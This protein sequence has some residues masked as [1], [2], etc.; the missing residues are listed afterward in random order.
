MECTP[1]L[2]RLA[3][4]PP[5]MKKE[6]NLVIVCAG[7]RDLRTTTE[8]QKLSKKKARGRGRT[9]EIRGDLLRA[10]F[11]RE[12]KKQKRKINKKEKG[13][14]GVRVK[15]PLNAQLHEEEGE[16]KKKKSRRTGGTKKGGASASH[17][18][19]GGGGRRRNFLVRPT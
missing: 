2:N 14:G 12:P 4:Q 7:K 15:G 19:G 10:A 5:K 17:R 18:A 3:L 16:K 9:K 6:R 8:S 11:E 13:K 1:H